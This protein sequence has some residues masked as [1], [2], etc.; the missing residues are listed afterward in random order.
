MKAVLKSLTHR[1]KDLVSHPDGAEPKTPAAVPQSATREHD[2]PTFTYFSLPDFNHI[3]LCTVLAGS[4]DDPIE[5]RREASPLSSETGYG[6][7]A[8]S[9]S[10]GTPEVEVE[11]LCNGA[12]MTIRPNLRAGLHQLRYPKRHRVL[13]IDRLCIDQCVALASVCPLC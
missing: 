9:Y 13:W 8:V 7:E 12:S 5:C 2:I 10:W 11:I 4:G 1:K 3:R 6:Y